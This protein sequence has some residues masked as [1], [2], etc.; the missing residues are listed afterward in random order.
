MHLAATICAGVTAGSLTQGLPAENKI[1]HIIKT[2]QTL[3]IKNKNK[4]KKMQTFLHYF[5]LIVEKE[6]SW[7]SSFCFPYKFC[8][9]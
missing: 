5:I 2:M 8:I 4:N 1:K 3:K 7:N 6:N 9:Y